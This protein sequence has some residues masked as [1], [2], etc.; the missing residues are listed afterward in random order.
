M[1]LSSP[2]IQE[3]IPVLRI[4]DI[5]LEPVLQLFATQELEFCRVERECAIPGS[6]WGDDEAGL[7]RKQIFAR[8]DTPV[9]SLM[10][11]ACHYFLMDDVRRQT[12]HT[13]AG[14]SS[15]EENAVCYLQICL[16]ST[17]AMVGSKRMMQD[18]DAWGYSFRLGSTAAWFEQDAEDAI[19]L[20]KSCGLWQQYELATCQQRVL[21]DINQR[22]T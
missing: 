15:T 1:D 10:H 9:H 16:A 17:L 22:H 14:G 3:S 7:I 21:S 13:D 20:L 2:V 19:A 8:G 18:M 6:H 4:A 5:D 11:E 12:L